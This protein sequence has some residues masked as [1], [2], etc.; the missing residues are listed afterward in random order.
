MNRAQVNET[1]FSCSKR[2]SAVVLRSLARVNAAFCLAS[3]APAA[4]ARI[5]ARV[6]AA[7][8]GHAADR[9]KSGR[10]QRMRRQ[11]RIAIDRLDLLARH[12]GE[13][14]ELQPR[15]VVLEDR[16]RAAD[17]TLKALASVDP[18]VK[19]LQRAGQRLDLADA[20]AC[21][22]IGKPEIAL[23]IFARQGFLQRLD[24]ADIA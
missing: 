15:T 9:E 21:I 12:I 2:G 24:R 11:V 19:R 16:N 1:E 10:D 13:G 4:G 17:A 20:A 23:G 6:A 8:A 14:I 3:A 7:G 18:G 22:G 5:L